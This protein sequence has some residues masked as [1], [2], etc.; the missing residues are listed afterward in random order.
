MNEQPAAPATG[1]DST[2]EQ[3]TRNRRTDVLLREQSVQLREEAVVQCEAAFDTRQQNAHAK[4]ALDAPVMAQLREANENLVMASVNAHAMTEAAERAG[5]QK[6]EF[7]AM[8]A[9]ELRNPLAP[10]VNAL[11]VLRRIP[12]TEPIVPWVHDIIKRQIDHMT[13]LLDDLLD[14]SRVTSGKIVLQKQPT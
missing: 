9:H 1:A 6:E 14:V 7:L 10:I 11:A 13:R 8:L 5:R 4:T 12:M 2:P 3:A